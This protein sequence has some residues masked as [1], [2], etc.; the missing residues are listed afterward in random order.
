MQWRTYLDPRTS[1][2]WALIAAGLLVCAAW[3]FGK[4]G[5]ALGALFAMMLVL[6]G[7]G[8]GIVSGWERH[9]AEVVERGTL[10]EQEFR[11]SPVGGG[12][13]LA[14]RTE[15]LEALTRALL[16]HDLA[17]F[18]VKENLGSRLQRVFR[19]LGWSPL[20]AARELRASGHTWSARLA[21]KAGELR[22]LL[23]E[24]EGAAAFRT[25]VG[26][27]EDEVA[28]RDAAENL[29]LASTRSGWTE[30]LELGRYASSSW[31]CAVPL[32]SERPGDLLA[33]VDGPPVERGESS[34][35]T[36]PIALPRPLRW[37]IG[38]C[39]E[40]VRAL[41]RIDEEQHEL[42]GMLVR[43]TRLLAASY[44]EWL[45]AKGVLDGRDQ[46]FFL[47]LPELLEQA[48]RPSRCL[49]PLARRRQA[50]HLRN[51]GRAMP[52]E[53][54]RPPRP[55]LSTGRAVVGVP[56]ASGRAGGPIHHL[57]SLDALAEVPS[58]A[59]LVTAAPNPVLAVLFG[60]IAALVT[61]S[62]SLLSHAFVTAREMGL[63]C[64]AGVD[65]LDALPEGE[66]VVVDGETG[67][68]RRTSE[69][70]PT[71]VTHLLLDLDGTLVTYRRLPSY[72][73]FTLAVLAAMVPRLGL[74]KTIAALIA[75][76]KAIERPESHELPNATR[77]AK[78][79][80]K[81]LSR[82]FNE[83]D[84]LY[85]AASFEAFSSLGSCFGPMPGAA[86]F[87]AWA[88][89]RYRLVLATN[90][91]WPRPLVELRLAWAGLQ[92]LEFDLVTH[93]DLMHHCK[94]SRGYYLELL[95]LLG[96]E[97]EQAV[98]LGDNPVKDGLAATCGLRTII[99][100]TTLPPELPPGTRA[101]LH[102]ATDFA[103]VIS[104]LEE[105]DRN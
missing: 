74:R 19:L 92:N 75:S 73:R 94:Y 71:R 6:G 83:A 66:E 8:R 45:V 99:L 50:L 46:V 13:A 72:V 63:P 16:L 20:V 53:L 65:D 11:E 102:G 51:L 24:D 104:L 82:P 91:M 37:A 32:L 48:Q 3:P 42:S 105:L 39:R 80:A 57:V 29:E 41:V 62:G 43:L 49:A 86:E 98:M 36:S 18:L 40:L 25:A 33:L 58:G 70:A 34:V 23:A 14:R 54:P 96:L 61:Q 22:G 1:R 56:M 21:A 103:S 9:V 87:L 77:A 26:R 76:R 44:G 81:V 4:L 59:V 15:A 30:L 97:P 35:P 12:G 88:Q 31:D 85:R 28:G 89:Q 64:V 52:I 2:F 69:T 93:G 84:S 100:G 95:E 55:K 78:A 47:T 38:A 79:V 101:G 7:K 17:I 67:L 27:A 5:R 90:P 10:L 68:V 60:R